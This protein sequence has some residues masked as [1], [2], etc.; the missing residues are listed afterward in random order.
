MN[1]ATT[2]P[3]TVENVKSSSLSK[4]P[5]RAMTPPLTVDAL[6]GPPDDVAS[7][8]PFTVVASTSDVAPSTLTAPLT[9]ETAIFTPRGTA[10]RKST[11]TSL[12]RT[13]CDS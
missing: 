13:L 1:S 4:R 10:T 2:V 12:L 11:L 8:S 6:T 9:L 5:M 3:F 7:T